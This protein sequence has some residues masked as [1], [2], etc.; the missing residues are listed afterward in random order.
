MLRVS[1]GQGKTMNDLK[2]IVHPQGAS[3]NEK[4]CGEY[5]EAIEYFSRIG[6]KI[7]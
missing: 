7:R 5:F 4:A 3:P 6:N 1:H 2:S